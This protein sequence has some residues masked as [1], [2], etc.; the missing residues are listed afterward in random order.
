[1]QSDN[2]NSFDTKITEL[3]NTA[4]GKLNLF[5]LCSGGKQRIGKSSSLNVIIS[6]CK[7]E[8]VN[9][10]KEESNLNSV[11]KQ[12]DTLSIQLQNNGTKVDTFF[13][14][15]EGS[16]GLNNSEIIK[17]YTIICAM[18]NLCIFH[19]E[20]S[21]SDGN[22]I[23]TVS[24]VIANLA[25]HEIKIPQIKILVRDAPQ[26]A[27]SNMLNDE[28]SSY[29]ELE[30][31]ARQHFLQFHPTLNGYVKKEDIYFIPTPNTE[32]GEYLVWK[33]ESQ[34]YKAM[35]KVSNDIKER[36]FSQYSSLEKS[37]CL[38][39]LEKLNKAKI[40]QVNEMIFNSKEKMIEQ[41]KQ[42]LTQAKAGRSGFNLNKYSAGLSEIIRFYQNV[43]QEFRTK[44]ADR[45]KEDIE[46]AIKPI[47]DEINNVQNE[48][49]SRYNV[50]YNQHE[51]NR[52][53]SRYTTSR[54]E[55]KGGNK[56]LYRHTGSWGQGGRCIN[57]G[58]TVVG[59]DCIKFKRH[60]GHLVKH[61]KK[62]LFITTREWKTYSCC[63][64][65]SNSEAC[66]YYER[67]KF[68]TMWSCCGNQNQN[69]NGCQSYQE[70]DNCLHSNTVLDT[71]YK[72]GNWDDSQF[73]NSF[74][75]ILNKYNLS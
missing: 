20:K 4:K 57:C 11:T 55:Y 19:V 58:D 31:K 5:I 16:G 28:T 30:E 69:S 44:Y 54:V 39:N 25:N 68:N 7:G 13:L 2:K 12:F 10:F 9:Y 56:T 1:M 41:A 60:P 15:C 66:S 17:Y 72:V 34:Y 53:Q 37:Y 64:R 36:I 29:S 6:N 3:I 63:G 61:T 38:S 23:S 59:K 52:L 27:L 42:L 75:T 74:K 40:I 67:C 65:G 73:V 8:K 71:H 21:F 50:E 51:T 43:I 22:F 26:K 62:V 49:N 48:L 47:N 24:Q 45:K 18:S 35:E 32:D 46:L 33:K 70:W 14:D